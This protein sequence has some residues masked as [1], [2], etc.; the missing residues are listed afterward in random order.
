MRL[1]KVYRYWSYVTDLDH[2]EIEYKPL[3]WS[4]WGRE[5]A[6]TNSIF[7]QLART[8]ARRRGDDAIRQ[9]E[10]DADRG[11]GADI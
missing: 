2:K 4:C 9:L 1:H 10:Q 7:R 5:H 6:N 8:A 3:I 11:G